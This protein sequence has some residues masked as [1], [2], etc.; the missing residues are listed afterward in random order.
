M[1]SCMG[2]RVYLTRLAAVYSSGTDISRHTYRMRALMTLCVGEMITSLD[3]VKKVQIGK[4]SG[5]PL[6]LQVKNIF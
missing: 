3:A 2:R 1:K 6:L 5:S 4:F